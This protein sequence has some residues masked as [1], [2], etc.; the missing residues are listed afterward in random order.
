VVSYKNGAGGLSPTECSL[1]KKLQ[2]W[3]NLVSRL[4][5][6]NLHEG[7][8]IFIWSLQENGSFSLRSMY[9]Y[10]I[11]SRIRVAQEI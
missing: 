2:E 6:I 8:D 5:N 11:S 9:K 7:K 4:V 10:L 1:K 3:H